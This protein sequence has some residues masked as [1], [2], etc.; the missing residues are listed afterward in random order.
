[1]VARVTLIESQ[2][3]NLIKADDK[4]EAPKKIHCVVRALFDTAT[5]PPDAARAIDRIIQ[6]DTQDAH[7]AYLSADKPTAEQLRN[8]DIRYPAPSDLLHWL[9]NC[10]GTA[11]MELTPHHK[12]QVYMVETL[13]ELQNLP[14]TKLPDAT[15]DELDEIELYNINPDNGYG[16]FA[17]WL[18]DLNQSESL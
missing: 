2:F 9:F 8:G 7:L 17:Q 5:Q 1:M 13:K 12:A 18:W 15:G 10:M 16:G 6:E 14:K 3:L 11:A 4:W